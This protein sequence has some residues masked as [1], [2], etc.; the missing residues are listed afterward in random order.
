M[1]SSKFDQLT[2]AQAKLDEFLRENDMNDIITKRNLYQKAMRLKVLA[3]S[4]L[5]N[6]NKLFKVHDRLKK[7]S[8]SCV[9]FAV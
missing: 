6:A 1:K 8:K 3:P 2:K 7:N 4:E 5:V 9:P